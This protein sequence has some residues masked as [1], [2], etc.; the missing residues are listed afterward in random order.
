MRATHALG[1]YQSGDGDMSLQ[2]TRDI[3]LDL[4]RRLSRTGPDRA[5][6]IRRPIRVLRARIDEINLVRPDWA[7]AV[8]GHA[9]MDDR[10]MLTRAG[11]G[12]EAFAAKPLN[13]LDRKSTR[14]N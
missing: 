9:I 4:R 3:R 1:K 5:R 8:I 14:L 13:R 7:V 10:A 12:G 6:D 2:H 11:D